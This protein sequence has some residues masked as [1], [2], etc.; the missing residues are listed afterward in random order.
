ML[1]SAWIAVPELDVPRQV[2]VPSY[3]GDTVDKLSEY[4]AAKHFNDETFANYWKLDIPPDGVAAAL[5]FFAL[6]GSSMG[7]RLNSGAS[8]YPFPIETRVVLNIVMD[9]SPSSVVEISKKMTYKSWNEFS[10]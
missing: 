10:L 2:D 9:N 4:I 8:K 3:V 5:L 7:V 1:P 6:E